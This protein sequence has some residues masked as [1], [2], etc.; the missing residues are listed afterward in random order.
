MGFGWFRRVSALGAVALACNMAAAQGDSKKTPPAGPP[1]VKPS[2]EVVM[3]KEQA[4]ELFDSVDEIMK[5]AA[6]DTD[7][8][9]V[10]HVKRKLVTRDEVNRYLVKNFDED[11][12]SK[13]LQRS[14]IVLKK[15][16]LL[17][18]DFNLRPFLLSLLTEQVAGFYDDKTKTVNMLN[19]V[20]PDQQKPVLAHELT[21]AIQDN[22]VGLTKWGDNGFHGLSHTASEDNQRVRTDELE[23][24]RQAV[25]EGQAM[26]VFIDWGLQGTGKTLATSPEIG[27]QMKEAA[28]D[29]TGAGGNSPVMARAPFLLQ[30]SLVFPYADGLAFEQALL[31]KGGKPAAFAGVL[32]SPPSSSF[33]IMHPDEYLA[34]AA[35]P[36]LRLPDVHPILDAD[37]E[38]YDLGV[39]G[40]LDVEIMATLFGGPQVAQAL[41]PAWSGGVYYAA[42][43]KS[44]TAAERTTAGSLGVFY[45]S[46]WKTPEA[47]QT[48][49][50]IYTGELGRK[51]SGLT[52]RRRDESSA[53][54]QVYTT[55]EG[56]VLLSLSDEGLFISEG[57]PLATARK[58]RE[59]VRDVQGTAP[60][61]IA[62]TPAHELTLGATGMLGALGTI[63]A[64]TIERYTQ[65]VPSTNQR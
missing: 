14:E 12:S 28:G 43:R 61:K 27:A 53:D 60:I 39:M 30:R 32:A 45:Y 21:H 65:H 31:L 29:T 48:F 15:F 44:A 18:R 22:K 16:G 50:R 59:R 26:V 58:L 1:L 2:T 23:T 25:A 36:V 62:V 37:Y 3:T 24:A 35:V 49:D 20:E 52:E 5:F 7:L 11:E 41:V 9:A 8:P 19:W 10:P 55:K 34:H 54:E 38:P 33:E 6:A 57:F 47:A 64:E 40:E 63:R 56:D 13:R 17:N 4:K 51:Y 46:R 42:Q